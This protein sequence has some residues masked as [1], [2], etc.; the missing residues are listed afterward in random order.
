MPATFFDSRY[1]KL[2]HGGIVVVSEVAEEVNPMPLVV[3]R[4]HGGNGERGRDG[5]NIY[6]WGAKRVATVGG[7]VG[8]GRCATKCVAW[9]IRRVHYQ[10]MVLHPSFSLDIV[11]DQMSFTLLLT[12]TG[13]WHR[14]IGI[15][16]EIKVLFERV[17]CLLLHVT[18]L[19]D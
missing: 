11:T 9:A 7:I 15:V 18:T 5:E 2:A 4:Q 12:R 19:L 10:R 3:G 8:L 13:W 17:Q 14:Y 6:G 1:A 16:A